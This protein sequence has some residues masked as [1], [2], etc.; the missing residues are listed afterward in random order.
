MRIVCLYRRKA[1]IYSFFERGG[2]GERG[3]REREEGEGGEKGRRER[4]AIRVSKIDQRLLNKKIVEKI[5]FSIYLSL[6]N[7]AVSLLLDAWIW[8]LKLL[9]T[10][11]I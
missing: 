8:I 6:S 10:R 3:R 4:V 1:H 2:R 5:N 9:G 7:Y 11:F